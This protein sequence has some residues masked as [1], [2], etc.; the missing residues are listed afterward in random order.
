MKNGFNKS[1]KGRIS[2]AER[3][4]LV[5]AVLLSGLAW[6]EWLAATNRSGRW[7]WLH[8]L[9]NDLLGQH[10]YAKFL[11]IAGLFW[12]VVFLISWGPRANSN[13]GEERT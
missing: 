12:F 13:R 5:L 7:A 4:Y 10:G 3:V 8:H 1:D 6:S 2:S 11:L 9:A